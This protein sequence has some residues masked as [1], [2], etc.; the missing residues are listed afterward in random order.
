MV[1]ECLAP[2]TRIPTSDAAATCVPSTLDYGLASRGCVL[3][4]HAHWEGVPADHALVVFTVDA[5]L[6]F[7]KCVKTHWTCRDE[8]GC[9]AFIRNTFPTLT[10]G[11]NSM[12]ASVGQFTTYISSVQREWSD[13]RSA[14]TRSFD[15]FP[16]RLRDL[17]RRMSCA[18]TEDERKSLQSQTFQLRCSLCHEH[19]N[20]VLSKSI[21]KGNVVSR[22]KKLHSIESVILSDVHPGKQNSVSYCHIE[23]DKEVTV[24]F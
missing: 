12:L 8:D 10:N 13:D 11:V 1:G 9:F 3:Q 18:P 23:M 22:S 21:E 24:N 7:K 20:R 16:P 2:I 17:C 14:R 6:V 15:R 5:K 4:C 19:R